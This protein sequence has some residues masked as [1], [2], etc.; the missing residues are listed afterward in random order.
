MNLDKLQLLQVSEESLKK[1]DIQ[2]KNK[3]ELIQQINDSIFR[4]CAR[5]VKEKFDVLDL[6]DKVLKLIRYE[7]N[8]TS[9]Q[10]SII[11][12]G[13]CQDMCPEKE[14]YSR[15]HLNLMSGYEILNGQIEHGL[16]VK[17]YS[18]SSADQDLPLPNELRPVNVMFETMLYIVDEVIAKIEA[19]NGW[20]DETT[21]G[22]WYVNKKIIFLQLVSIHMR[23]ASG[24]VLG[25]IWGGI[26]YQ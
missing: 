2:A 7:I 14:R 21:T 10:Q 9:S 18:R 26:F 4:K 13:T 25:A 8:Q 3:S 1:F 19:K 22:D 24:V 5:T 17:E 23:W 12:I 11:L 6:R 15:E 16:M 20:L